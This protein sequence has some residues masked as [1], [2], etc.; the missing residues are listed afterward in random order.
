[1]PPTETPCATSYP[2]RGSLAVVAPSIEDV[3]KI[4]AIFRAWDTGVDKYGR[5]AGRTSPAW[6]TCLRAPARI[7]E[8][9]ALTWADLDL[10]SAPAAVTIARAIAVDENARLRV[11]DKPKSDTSRRALRLPAAVANMPGRRSRRCSATRSASERRRTSSGTHRS[12]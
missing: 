6:P 10:S 4:R 8:V 9:L 5:P 11:Q 3:P 2:S 1:M 7:G 12:R